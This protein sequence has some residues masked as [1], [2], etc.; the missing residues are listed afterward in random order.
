MNGWCTSAI[1]QYVVGERLSK[2]QEPEPIHAIRVLQFP[3][4]SALH[5]HL[6]SFLDVLSKSSDKSPHSPW[7]DVHQMAFLLIKNYI[8]CPYFVFC[9]H[10]YFIVLLRLFNYH[11]C[12]N[13]S[14]PLHSLFPNHYLLF[15]IGF[16]CLN[17]L[18]M[19]K[20]LMH[21][22]LT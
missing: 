12:S 17:Y 15:I 5:K 2:F 4:V 8:L 9:P 14:C 11:L 13:L 10:P 20:T 18:I 16:A 19:F 21:F 1:S 3:L 22:C 6:N 7:E